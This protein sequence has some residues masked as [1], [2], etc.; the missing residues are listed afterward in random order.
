MWTEIQPVRTLKQLFS[1]TRKL[2]KDQKEIQG[3]SVINWQ[4]QTWQRTTLLTDK[5]VQFATAKTFVFSD[6]VLCMVGISGNP[7]SAWKEKIDWF[8]NSLGCR[9]LN[10][11]GGEPVE[12]KWKNFPG[13]TKL[14]IFAEIQNMMT[15]IQGEP[16]QFQGRIIFVSM[17]DDIVW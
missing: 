1:V 9:E 4:Q 2:I 13:F 3:I 10:R 17:Y 5:A 11:I 12:L 15:E 16:E 8:Q 7:V 14:H 6:S